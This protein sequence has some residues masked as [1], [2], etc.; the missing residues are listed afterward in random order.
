MRVGKESPR[1]HP[2]DAL[3]H[4]FVAGEL[5]PA[6]RAA[7]TSH[8]D[9][10]P[11]CRASRTRIEGLKS[12]IAESQP[13]G[14]DELK[15]RRISQGVMARLETEALSSHHAVGSGSRAQWT[16]AALAAAAAVA[17]L[18]WFAPRPQK[19]KIAQ[20]ELAEPQL[21]SPMITSGDTTFDL[22]LPQG[23]SLHLSEGA[24]LI[25]RS[26]VPS[27]IDLELQLG[28]LDLRALAPLDPKAPI[29]VRT[30]DFIAVARS[31]D[32]SIGYQAAESFVAVRE[33]E[34]ELEP[35]DTVV[36]KGETHTIRHKDST[37][38]LEEQPR[39]KIASVK[40]KAPA[41]QDR[42]SWDAAGRSRLDVEAEPERVEEARPGHR[43]VEAPHKISSEGQTSVSMIAPPADVWAE[44]WRQADA[45]YTARSY[46]RAISIANDIVEH[47]GMRGEVS[48]AREMLCDLYIQT[49][50][51]KQA[52][53][54]CNALLASSTQE[55][56]RAVHYKLATI[57]RK[58]LSD[59][60]TAIV[61]YTNA[62]VFGRA[63]PFDDDAL[64]W[65]ARC[66]IEIGD[67]G[68]ARSDIAA[69]ERRAAGLARPDELDDLKKR[70]Q[71]A[72]R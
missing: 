33:G 19:T 28:Q 58:E 63:S 49:N 38:Q 55:E 46:D 56:S 40:K 12:L 15:W 48:M 66:S 11:E 50:K 23:L 17:L 69:L 3:L 1:R 47:A 31:M 60:R 54:A 67:L 14:F 25:A 30:P 2:P 4:A 9:V 42:E 45:A 7:I 57:H 65:R 61:H 6:H 22:Q 29:K 70:L 16:I 36:K 37:A 21:S 39:E 41:T 44:K 62:M 64:I 13:A 53:D 18:V 20:Q 27:D 71:H 32:F 59:C 24:R 72:V 68:S 26:T 5:D 43:A 34:V 51:P 8:L 35:G 10:C 52:V